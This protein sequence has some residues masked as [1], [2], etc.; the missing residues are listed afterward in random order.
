MRACEEKLRALFRDAGAGEIATPA[1]EYAGTL[2]R[3]FG[4]PEKFFRL[5]DSDGSILALRPEL[6]TPAA[7][8]YATALADRPLPLRIYYL[9][10]VYRQ[11]PK[12]KGLFREFRQAGY[13]CYGG[14]Q[15]EE[16][17]R[18]VMLASQAL[19]RLGFDEALFEIGHV[20]IVDGLLDALAP[21]PA[22]RSAWKDALARKDIPALRELKAPDEL[23]NLLRAT[24][25]QEIRAL[26]RNPAVS[27]AVDQLETISSRLSSLPHRVVTEPAAIRHLD[28]YTG[29]VFDGL[30]PRS[31]RPVLSGGRY[32]RLVEQ[33]GSPAAAT[34]FS[35]EL[36]HLLRR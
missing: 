23:L 22:T 17:V 3:G 26:S 30:L 18:A 31:S 32:D 1:F 28:Y 35:L 9:G 36:E 20:G 5:L 15:V 11:E 24:C 25:G 13:E 10:Q 19:S 29:L 2:E 27:A 33:F 34:G 8:L 6:T 7:R 4:H 21:P 14:D 16:D 12:H